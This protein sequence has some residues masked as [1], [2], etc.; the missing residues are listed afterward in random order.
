[1][2][3]LD[4]IPMLCMD[5]H[6]LCCGFPLP[7]IHSFDDPYTGGFCSINYLP[8]VLLHIWFYLG[9]VTVRQAGPTTQASL[10]FGAPSPVLQI[11]YNLLYSM[12]LRCSSPMPLISW[13]CPAAVSLR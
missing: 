9:L 3:T 7:W 4:N 6:V 5:A 10:D 11:R 2:P 13:Y 8:T 12:G 1:M